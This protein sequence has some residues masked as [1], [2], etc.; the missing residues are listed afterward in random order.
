M[1]VREGGG[2]ELVGEIRAAERAV[3][4]ISVPWSGPDRRGRVEFLQAA[5]RCGEKWPTVEVAW[6]RLEVDEDEVSERWLGSVG[7]AEFACRGAGAVLWLESGRVVSTTINAGALGSS[8]IVE[9]TV[10]LWS[11]SGSSRCAD[12]GDRGRVPTATYPSSHDR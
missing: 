8:G 1:F 3:V 6:F 11:G 10:A 9:Q 4:L 5:A 12:R 7:Q 2:V